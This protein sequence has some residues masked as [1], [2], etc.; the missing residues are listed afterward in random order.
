VT[1]P[2]GDRREGGVRRRADRWW[3][4]QLIVYL[5][6][7]I[8]VVIGFLRIE[9]LV[10]RVELE[11]KIRAH[12][13]CNSANQSRQGIRLYLK[14]LAERDGEITDQ[15]VRALD[16]AEDFFGALDCPPEP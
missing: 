1:Q 7:V 10:D 15:E 8:V 14:F 4:W 5:V 11:G 3:R 13:L 2:E 9:S 16:S 6:L 12:E